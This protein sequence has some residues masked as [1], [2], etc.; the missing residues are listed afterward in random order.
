MVNYQLRRPET[1]PETSNRLPFKDTL[2]NELP[3]N[4]FLIAEQDT[5]P[6]AVLHEFSLPAPHKATDNPPMGMR[7]MINEGLTRLLDPQPE[8]LFTRGLKAVKPGTSVLGLLPIL[9]LTST[10]GLL[11]VSFSYYISQYGNLA[12]EFCFLSGLL[13]I[14]GPNAARLISR[15]P[16]RLERI[17]LLCVV[18]VC[19]YL[20][21]FMVSPLH[22]YSVD[23][24]MH[25]RT[26]NDIVRS[27]HLFSENSLLPVSPYYPGLE[28]VTDALSTM[29]G[30]STFQASIV[31]IGASRLLMI[32][33]LF[34]LYE[35]LTKSSRMAGIATLIYIT[36]PQFLFFDAQFAYET[37][38]LPL[39]IFML[40]I[41]ARCET[42]NKDSRWILFTA[43]IVLLAITITHHMT[44]YNFDGLLILWAV[45]SLFHTS[46]RNMPRNLITIAL[47]GVLLSLA[48][49][50]LLNGNLAWAYLSDYFGTAFNEFGN[51][52][53]GNSPIR[54][55]FVNQNA[56]PTPIWDRL[57]MTAGVALVVL[58][59]PFGLLSFWKQHRHNAL[60]LTFGI[61][62]LAYP[63]FQM[64]RFTELG[65]GIAVRSA[66]F[67]FL[68][69][70]YVLTILISQLWPTRK[71]SRRTT[72][73]ITGAIV[74]VFV[75]GVILASG[76]DWQ[77]LPGP[78]MV[79]A[80]A[81]SV[82]PEGIQ[83]A[84]WS[85]SYLGPDN[86]VGTDRINRL[87][88][89]SYGEQ[90]VVTGLSDKIDISPV[91]FST[92]FGSEEAAIMR[93]ADLR[94]LVV[95][96][97]LSMSLPLEGYYF[98]TH[99]SGAYQHTS[100]I[101]REALTKFNT[102]SQI[103]RIFDSG[104]IVIYDAGPLFDESS[105]KGSS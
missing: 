11:I 57:M 84:S 49:T 32:L 4:Q 46:S 71:L 61:S 78:Y 23:E 48:Y 31:V 80:D 62:S 82:E 18:G 16:L 70:S 10:F 73:L 26:V 45:I 53:V 37:L 65:T 101:S 93:R 2:K 72:S 59:L 33:S 92:Q 60:A 99:E 35:Q 44:D 52:I 55:L 95:D 22:F 66:A 104:D 28:I 63:V 40:Y 68:P 85:L 41:L 64:F 58:S 88:M 67:L 51:I 102:I 97:R 17:C 30:L 100:P 89:T 5:V 20:V 81:R 1:L 47:F 3:T 77:N 74:M 7:R 69:V 24:F 105:Q 39:G 13:L 15:A 76:L 42:M 29:T 43:Y 94:Y 75:G 14:F 90:R 21:R 27:G 25:W 9:T 86:R 38:A 8:G 56:L 96:L 12:F 34:M 36:N 54:P 6:L 98:E 91:F 83:A 79:L 19:F 50:F 87:L 103:N